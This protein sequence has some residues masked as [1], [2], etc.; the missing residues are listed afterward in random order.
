MRKRADHKREFQN[1]YDEQ[2]NMIEVK[3]YD[4]EGLYD[5]NE[6]FTYEYDQQGN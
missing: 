5:L 6:T 4:E 1:K 2:G 3:G